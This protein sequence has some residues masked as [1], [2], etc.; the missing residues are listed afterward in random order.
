[1]GPLCSIPTS[2]KVE[3]SVSIGSP[4]SLSGSNGVST[5]SSDQMLTR[6]V[7]F[8]Q[9]SSLLSVVSAGD[10][11]RVSL[12]TGSMITGGLSRATSA[13]L[14]NPGSIP[15]VQTG[16]H[17]RIV[18]QCIFFVAIFAAFVMVGIIFRKAQR[19]N[20]PKEALWWIAS[21]APFL[22]LRGIYG[23]LSSANWQYS[24]YL[25]TNVSHLTH[26]KREL[27]RSMVEMD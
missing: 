15:R 13:E 8:R 12:I 24:Y 25:P 4:M 23:I 3:T 21:T 19:L 22:I 6:Q 27:I 1:L 7:S 10:V 2:L 17:L 26:L 9:M 18:G 11:R 16:Q 20:K 5:N 14:A